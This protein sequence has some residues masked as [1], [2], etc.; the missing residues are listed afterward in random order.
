[1]CIYGSLLL[2]G[3]YRASHNGLTG[4]VPGNFLTDE[5]TPAVENWKPATVRLSYSY[6]GA[7]EQVAPQ[8]ASEQRG[9]GEAPPPQAPAPVVQNLKPAPS[10]LPG[11][12]KRAKT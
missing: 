9:R 11:F 5:L 10:N 8:L 7:Q 2:Q 1:M 4:V 12:E 3:W 6:Y